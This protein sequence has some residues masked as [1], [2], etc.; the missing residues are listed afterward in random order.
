MV[1]LGL[2]TGL[3]IGELIG[4]KRSDIDLVVG[5]L[6]VNRNDWKGILGLPKGGK[7]REIGLNE[8]ATTYLKRLLPADAEWVFCRESGDRL[9]HAI[10]RRPI[11]KACR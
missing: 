1:A 9:T 2:N 3:R 4:L 8:T 5:R 7:R 6:V 10:C 11:H